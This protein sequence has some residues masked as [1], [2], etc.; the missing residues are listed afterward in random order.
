MS[1]NDVNYIKLVVGVNIYIYNW[2]RFSWCFSSCPNKLYNRGD[3]FYR[4]GS[5]VWIP[6]SWHCFARCIFSAWHD[7]AMS[8]QLPK[9][10][11][12][13]RWCETASW[14]LFQVDAF[15]FWASTH[16]FRLIGLSIQAL[17]GWK[18]RYPPIFWMSSQSFPHHFWDTN[19]AFPHCAPHISRSSQPRNW[20]KSLM[21]YWAVAFQNCS[22][23]WRLRSWGWKR[24][25]N[26]WFEM[27]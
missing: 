20:M 25:R 27:P 5:F 8:Q 1:S 18:G 19:N 14:Y 13:F 6:T 24:A 2:Y 9:W 15:C 3:H 7:A 17:R 16:F 21:F 23:P 26:W 4:C 12:I 11:I 22:P 10:M